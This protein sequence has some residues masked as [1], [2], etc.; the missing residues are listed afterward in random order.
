MQP[1][2]D[3][4]RQLFSLFVFCRTLELTKFFQQLKLA[5]DLLPR[6]KPVGCRRSNRLIAEDATLGV[7]YPPRLHAPETGIADK[8]AVAMR[9]S[10]S[11]IQSVSGNKR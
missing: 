10:C 3:G 9:P 4:Q 6:R 8:V 1:H 2:Y 7:A 5:T 11:F